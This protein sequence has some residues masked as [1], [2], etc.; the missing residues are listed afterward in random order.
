MLFLTQ[1]IQLVSQLS[2]PF[3]NSIRLTHLRVGVEAFALALPFFR[4]TVAAGIDISGDHL[5]RIVHFHILHRPLLLLLLLLLSLLLLVL[6]LSL[7]LLLLLVLSL[8]LP[9]L[10]LLRRRRHLHIMPVGLMVLLTPVHLPRLPHGRGA[11]VQA[12]V[13]GVGPG[14]PGEAGDGEGA[15]VEEAAE[16]GRG[17]RGLGHRPAARGVVTAL[18]EVAAVHRDR[19]HLCRPVWMEVR[20][21]GI[22][23]RAAGGGP[24]FR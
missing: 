1:G 20:R 22:R 10:L 18:V 23:V 7:P 11:V 6:P 13:G 15:A 2:L 12:G 14:S 17:E 24:G 21:L 16:L 3:F 19:H 8:F 9:L 5:S 4:V